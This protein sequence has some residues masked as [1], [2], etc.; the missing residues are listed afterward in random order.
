MKHKIIA[1]TIALFLLLLTGCSNINNLEYEEIAKQAVSQSNKPNV[2]VRG[3]KIFL[4][5]G[6]AIVNDNEDNI[7]I[8]SNGE[9][10]YL[11]VDVISYYN[12]YDNDYTA[13]KKD[14][15][16]DEIVEVNDKK[17]H[18]SICKYKNKY[19]LEVNYNYGKIEVITNN[20]K[21]ALTKSLLILNNTNF[22]DI[23]L[24]SLIGN[25]NFDYN[26]TQFNLEQ[27]N[28]KNNSSD[29]LNYDENYG[30]YEDVDDEIPDEDS[31]K[32]ENT[33]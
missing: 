25:S 29:I 19:F 31:I 11:Y 27:P 30:T 26:E 1:I 22:N 33:D 5:I 28:S 13:N 6:M 32:I 15:L 18:I 9:T 10:Y 8:S 17:M 23:I 7:T 2:A 16:Y 24:E 12:K 3:Y 4:P 14:N 20:V 21:E